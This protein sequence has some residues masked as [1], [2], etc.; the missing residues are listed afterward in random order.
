[1]L[2][3]V[4]AGLNDGL[5][6]APGASAIGGNAITQIIS[7]L[8][9]GR[10]DGI[11]IKTGRI[12][13]IQQHEQPVGMWIKHRRDRFAPV[14]VRQVGGEVRLPDQRR[15]IASVV[16]GNGIKPKQPDALRLRVNC[17]K[18]TRPIRRHDATDDF[19]S[20]FFPRRFSRRGLGKTTTQR[21]QQQPYTTTQKPDKRNT[22]IIHARSMGDCTGLRPHPV[23]VARCQSTSA[24]R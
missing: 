17:G 9:N 22:T 23:L 16:I 1:M 6:E 13:G 3:V 2:R 7:L 14:T 4:V 18:K 11:W 24:E 8:R 10:F 5:F 21:A 20:R 12:K 19:Q 15:P